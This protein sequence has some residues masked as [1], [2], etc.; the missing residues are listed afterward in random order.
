MKMNMFFL[1][2]K[3]GNCFKLYL[4]DEFKTFLLYIIKTIVFDL[5]SI[6]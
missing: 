4:G 2:E 3:D 1:F 6:I 5:Y